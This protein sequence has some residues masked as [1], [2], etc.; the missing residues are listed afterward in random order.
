M[1]RE[2]EVGVRE[3]VVEVVAWRWEDEVNEECRKGRRGR[4]WRADAGGARET[5]AA[6]SGGVAGWER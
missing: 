3:R 2:G 4:K 5:V 1:R 6:R